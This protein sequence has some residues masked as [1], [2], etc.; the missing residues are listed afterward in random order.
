[1]GHLHDARN[2]ITLDLAEL[3]TH[4]VRHAMLGASAQQLSLAFDFRGEHTWARAD[5]LALSCGLHRLLSAAVD[6]LPGPA[7]LIDGEAKA[8]PAGRLVAGIRVGG[9]GAMWRDAVIDEL[10]HRLQ[11]RETA[12]DPARERPR[13]RRAHGL[14]P[15]T[16]A[17]IEFGCSPSAG[18]LL[19]YRIVVDAD[20]ALHETTRPNAAHARAWVIDTDPQNA[21]S[22]ARRLQRLGWATTEFVSLGH[23]MRRLRAMPAAHARPALVVA[24]EAATTSASELLELSK[25]LPEQSGCVLLAKPGSASF[26]ASGPLA[27]LQV[28][29]APLSPGDLKELTVEYSPNAQAA[30]GYTRPSPLLEFERPA[31]LVVDD[32]E[33][34]RVIAANMVETLGCTAQLACDGAEAIEACRRS[35]PA[36]V[37]MD[38]SM[39][40]MNGI[41]ASRRMRELQHNGDM[42][43]F[44]VVAATSETSSLTRQ[45][46]FD[47]GMDG[48]L[49]KPLLRADLMGELQR[50]LVAARPSG[51]GSSR[52]P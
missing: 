42:P 41:D 37:L 9:N 46:C 11:L 25:L 16:G 23:A 33:V 51:S 34:N 31:L 35:P 36:L 14:C 19:H 43:P 4:A 28:R 8:S 39:P 5:P 21:G 15:A 45:R 50:L 29:A 52:E 17:H 47:A 7:L 18:F 20:G 1:M 48:F 22:L 2:P 30:S 10:L 6:L 3:V 24:A 49:S 44:A 38:V 32:D 12:P 13:L 27:G 26:S 40:R